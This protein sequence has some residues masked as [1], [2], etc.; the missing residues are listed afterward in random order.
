[1]S[2]KYIIVGSVTYAIKS[3]EI[4]ENRGINVKIEKIKKVH[5]LKGCG[6]G[7]KVDSAK[8]ATAARFLNTA[9]INI[10]DIIDCEVKP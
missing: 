9:G 2:C 6:F 8:S 4:L 3:K 1:M 7:L 10:L 5:A